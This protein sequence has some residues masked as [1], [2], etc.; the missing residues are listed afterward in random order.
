MWKEPNNELKE[1]SEEIKENLKFG[2]DLNKSK[3][4]YDYLEKRVNF[5]NLKMTPE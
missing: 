3:E 5:I 1:V 2:V 4:V